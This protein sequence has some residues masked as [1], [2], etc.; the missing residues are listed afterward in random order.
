MDDKIMEQELRSFDFSLCH[1]VREKLLDELLTM[2]RKDNGRQ[3]RWQGRMSDEEL[4]M[5]AAAGNPA[6]QEQQ[7]KDK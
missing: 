7:D 5:A 4:D 6:L 3:S 2:H 1:P